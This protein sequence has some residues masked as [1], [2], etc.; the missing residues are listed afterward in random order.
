MTLEF[1]LL[2]TGESNFLKQDNL[3]QLENTQIREVAGV[4][5]QGLKEG[6]MIINTNEARLYVGIKGA[7]GLANAGNYT[8]DETS[9]TDVADTSGNGHDGTA[10]S[11]NWT[12]DGK[13]N[14]AFDTTSA[15]ISVPANSDFDWDTIDFTIELWIKPDGAGLNSTIMERNLA[16]NTTSR[17]RMMWATSNHFRFECV[18]TSG[19][20]NVVV[21]TTG[22]SSG[23]WT[24]VAIVGDR[25]G[26]SLKLYI[27]GILEATDSLN[28][29]HDVDS[30]LLIGSR[31]D[32]SGNF[33]GTLDDIKI[34]KSIRT[35]AQIKQ[36][37]QK[38]TGL[39]WAFVNLEPT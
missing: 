18:D 31:V 27:N 17:C 12:T 6:T 3:T 2:N 37:S 1:G 14:G 8:L 7:I 33:P 36:D 5:E 23:T 20:S 21:A 32:G 9:G 24:H 4:P 39:S 29:T 16:A 26:N 10:T 15:E 13:F 28:I 35:A 11:G 34:W 30:A 38:L 19:G 25:S 22:S